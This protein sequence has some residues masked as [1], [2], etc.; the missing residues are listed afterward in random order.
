MQLEDDWR[1]ALDA[2]ARARGWPTS[3]QVS[4]LAAQVA[5]LSSQYNAPLGAEGAAPAPGRGHGAMAARLG[6][7]LPRDVPK[8]TAAVRELAAHGL[9]RPPQGR[10]LRVLDLGAGLGATTWGLVRALPRGAAVDVTWIEPDPLALE[11]ALELAR[12][13]AG[14]SPDVRVRAVSGA[15]AGTTAAASSPFDVILVGQ[16]LSELDPHAPAADRVAAHAA[17]LGAWMERLDPAGSLVVIEPAL[18]ARSRHLHAV[19][20]ALLA[21][22]TPAAPVTVFAPCLHAVGCPLVAGGEATSAAGDW[23]HEDRRVDLPAWLVPVARAA[24]LRWQ[25][26]TF[27]Y[28]VLRR[29]GTTLRS[30][31]LAP[32]ALVRVVSD[33]FVTKG[34]SEVFVCGGLEGSAQ[35]VRLMR[36]DRHRSPA[37]AAWDALARGD[38]VALA[39]PPTC[40]GDTTVEGARSP[41]VDAGTRVEVRFSPH[42]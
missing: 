4:A 18:R 6:F 10:P 22:S 24:G 15:I 37:N 20:D 30:R 14:S 34:K 33:R 11:V 38:C 3:Q 26:L 32:G 42:R 8:S 23:C 13:R 39:P 25:G 35:R 2:V 17:L 40:F 9:L 5:A 28:L 36:L 29:D 16:V 21:R 12:A 41:R 27:S 19:H 31:L 1:D 7:S